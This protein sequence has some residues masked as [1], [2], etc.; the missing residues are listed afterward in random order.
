[1]N[2]ARANGWTEKET[3]KVQDDAVIVK[4]V[5]CDA[6]KE[7]VHDRRRTVQLKKCTKKKCVRQTKRLHRLKRYMLKRKLVSF[8]CF[9]CKTSNSR[10]QSKQWRMQ[11]KTKKEGRERWWL[12]IVRVCR[13]CSTMSE[14]KKNNSNYINDNITLA[15]NSLN[16]L[17]KHEK[18]NFIHTG[19]T[20]YCLFSSSLEQNKCFMHYHS[21]CNKNEG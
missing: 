13:V 20:I 6:S 9:E 10:K 1:M 15:Q 11:T 19:F 4:L 3:L 8:R 12:E 2:F 17:I 14:C 16:V 5:Q 18:Q 7:C 21:L